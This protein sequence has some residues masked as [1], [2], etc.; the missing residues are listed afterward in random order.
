MSCVSCEFAG[1]TRV[2]LHGKTEEAV[3]NYLET[4]VLSIQVIETFKDSWREFSGARRSHP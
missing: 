1:G 4:V 2:L 3:L